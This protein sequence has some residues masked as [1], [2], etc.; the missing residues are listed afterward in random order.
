MIKQIEIK[1]GEKVYYCPYCGAKHENLTSEIIKSET[2]RC[3][4]DKCNKIFY[5]K[6]IDNK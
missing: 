1:K 3:L 4:N 5:L 2:A 6:V